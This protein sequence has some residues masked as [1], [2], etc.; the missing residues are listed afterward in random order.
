MEPDAWVGIQRRLLIFEKRDDRR[1]LFLQFFAVY[2]K[3]QKAM[4]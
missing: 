3:I 2:N 1:Q 4:L